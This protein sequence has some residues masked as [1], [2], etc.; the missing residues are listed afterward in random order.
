[1]PQGRSFHIRCMQVVSY[2]AS[3]IEHHGATLI[4]AN[5][6]EMQVW[7]CTFTGDVSRQLVLHCVICLGQS[8]LRRF[9]L[10]VPPKAEMDGR[11]SHMFWGTGI[12]DER[13]LENNPKFI[14]VICTHVSICALE[15]T[16][17]TNSFARA[18]E[19]CDA[20]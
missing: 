19:A 13:F 11:N 7:T 1:M 16:I 2:G 14:V 8:N 18:E 6:S 12:Q 20:H 4:P 17:S 3:P 5:V 10:N 9:R 15:A